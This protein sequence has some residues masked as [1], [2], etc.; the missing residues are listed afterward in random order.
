MNAPPNVTAIVP[1]LDRPDWLARSLAALSA[2]R[3]SFSK[4]LVADQSE[5]LDAVALCVQYGAERLELD[6]RGLSRARNVAFANVSTDWV[7]FP[8]DDAEVSHDILARLGEV[9]V[10]S[11]EAAFVQAHVVYP[12]G[13][14]MQAGMDGRERGLNN[15]A[16]LLR[17]TV[18]P[19]MFVRRDWIARVGGFDER[20][21]VGALYPSG[22]E[23][24][25]LIRI[26]AAGGIG[27]YAPSLRVQHPDPLVI[28]DPEA[29]SRRMFLY[30]VGLGALFAKHAA[31]GN[32]VAFRAQQWR[33]E[34][35]A[36]LGM[37]LMVL[38]GRPAQGRRYF[39]S[40][41]GRRAGW[42]SYLEAHR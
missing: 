37:L 1:T 34:A 39:E 23:S 18:S 13:A 40:W 19:G 25:L 10:R 8:D 29:Q 24:D 11:P 7:A 38:I 12:S 16:D 27:V 15:L 3:P 28:R 36:L 26:L 42:R 41:R 5:G 30:G 31:E 22:E 4:V 32:G 9:L 20:F 21:G 14:P 33:H 2:A 6:V 17:T 35:R